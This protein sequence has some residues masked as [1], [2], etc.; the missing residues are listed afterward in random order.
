[1]PPVPPRDQHNLLVVH[2][3]RW[4]GFASLERVCEATGL[5]ESDAESELIDL[6]VA[7]LVE[8]L[9]GDFGGWGLTEAGK[10]ADTVRIAAELD[11]AGARAAVAEAYK[12]LLELH[13]ELL[14]LCTTWRL[15]FTESGAIPNDHTDRI[16]DS[17]VLG[18]LAEFNQRADFVC[19]DLSRALLRFERYRARLTNALTRSNAGD[20]DYVTGGTFSYHVVWFQLQED[21][22]ATLEVPGTEGE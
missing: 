22:L 6:A 8:Y 7:G 5:S 1:M 9:R 10:A 11:S 20:L 3:L 14:D 16:Y 4:M 17:R 2:S 13:R 19:A 21:P 12:E 18:R 15:R